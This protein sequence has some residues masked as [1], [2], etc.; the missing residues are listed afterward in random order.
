[1]NR[2][3]ILVDRLSPQA[4]LAQLTTTQTQAVIDLLCLLT[5]AD[6]RISALEQLEFEETLMKMEWATGHR[7]VVRARINTASAP[8]RYAAS[9]EARQI[10][11]KKAINQLGETV[12]NQNESIFKLM[13]SMA[14]SDLIFHAK[15]RE[16]LSSIATGL[17]IAN[18]R[19]QELQEAF[20]S[21]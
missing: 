16:I 7:Q 18:A 2:W 15:E 20:G 9:T 3:S 1:M 21:A 10:L 4:G 6:N 13:A 19:A 17:G 5:Y 8:A 11:L 12:E 14:Y